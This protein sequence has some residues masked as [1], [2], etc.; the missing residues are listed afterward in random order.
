VLKEQGVNVIG[1][2]PANLAGIHHRDQGRGLLFT[3]VVEDASPVSHTDR[4]PH[5]VPNYQKLLGEKVTIRLLRATK[6]WTLNPVIIRNRYIKFN[7]L[8]KRGNIWK[9][10]TGRRHWRTRLTRKRIDTPDCHR[11]NHQQGPDLR[12]YMPPHRRGTC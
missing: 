3:G 11:R 2:T 9:G 10:A 1:I 4:Y 5:H 12:L 8:M 7:A 6:G